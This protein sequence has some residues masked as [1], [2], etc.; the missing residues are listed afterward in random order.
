M[1]KPRLTLYVSGQ[2][3]RSL[4]AAADLRRLCDEELA[5]VYDLVVID[6]LERPQ[7]A[8][9]EHILATPTVVK[10]RPGPCRRVIGDLSD[11]DQVILGLDLHRDP[12]E[13][14]PP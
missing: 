1:I 6:V 3:P 2:T 7:L 14:A 13:G 4:R 8:A 9:R 12:E 11:P 5:G 10:E